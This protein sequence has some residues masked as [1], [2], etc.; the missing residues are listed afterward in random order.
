MEENTQKKT[1][2]S[3]MDILRSLLSKLKLLI[4]ILIGGM[5]VGAGLG[6]LRTH[7]VE[8]YGTELKFYINPSK[9]AGDTVNSDSQYGVYGA[10]GKNVMNNMVELLSS[11][12]FAE[13]LLL[14]ELGLPKEERVKEVDDEELEELI[15]TAT[16]AISLHADKQ[17]QTQEA[18]S[19]LNQ[20]T[21]RLNTLWAEA[22]KNDTT[23]KLTAT[24]VK[25]VTTEIDNAIDAH[26]AAQVTY[27]GLYKESKVLYDAAEK[28][29]EKAVDKWRKVDKDFYTRELKKTVSAVK[30]SYYDET[31][32]VD[33]DDLARSF[34]YVNISVLNDKELAEEL[35]E[36]LIHHVPEYIEE[37]MPVPTGYDGTSCIR[38]S[39]T[40][41]VHQTNDGVVAKT[42]AKYGLI[43]GAAALVV[44]A[45]VVVIIDRSDKRLR[46][47]E[48]ITDLFNVPVLGVIPSFKTSQREDEDEKET[49]KKSTTE[50]QS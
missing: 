33:V 34:I 27:D 26:A 19:T 2:T 42:A 18:L 8:Y 20:A 6:F 17:A 49:T 36:L 9:D 5:I 31:A 22:R 40:D 1:E 24:P 15:A 14:D 3:I 43:L 28:A 39:R 29:R 10:Y 47:V 16:V 46:N 11:E 4:L 45:V 38:I 50:V 25:G 23:G 35:R 13:K 7:N 44:A 48:Q 30:Y 41:E 32:N 37:K 12:A 21:E